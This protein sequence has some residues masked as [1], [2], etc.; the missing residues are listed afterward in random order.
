MAKMRNHIKSLKT[1]LENL[2]NTV[3]RHIGWGTRELVVTM[4]ASRTLSWGKLTMI[5]AATGGGGIP[6]GGSGR[7]FYPNDLSSFLWVDETADA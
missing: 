5:Q 6:A 2:Q 3:A 4:P 7:F 1:A